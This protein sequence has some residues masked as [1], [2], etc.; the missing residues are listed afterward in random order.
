MPRQLIPYNDY[1]RLRIRS[2]G[3]LPHWEIEGATYA[4]TYRLHDSLPIDVIRRLW[5][6]RQAMGHQITDGVRPLTVIEHCR[7]D[8]AF[9]ELLDNEL[10]VERGACHLRNAQLADV[11]TENLRHFAGT[12]YELFAWSVMPNHIH[13]VFKPNKGE[14]LDLILHSWK[15]YTAHMASKIVGTKRLWAPEYFDRIIR[16]E[17]HLANAIAYTRGNPAKAGLVE[18]RWVG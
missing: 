13:V 4:I 5:R 2:R 18:W 7:I 11:V 9:G 12:R 6:E 16:D 1:R 17:R 8:E 14:T 15:S 3:Y 10:H